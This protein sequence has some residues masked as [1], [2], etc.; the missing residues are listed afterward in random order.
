MNQKVNALLLLNLVLGLSSLYFF[1][2][3]LRAF[4]VP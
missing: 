2:A 4:I 1:L 3:V